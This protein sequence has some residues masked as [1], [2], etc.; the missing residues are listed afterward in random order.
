MQD[1]ENLESSLTHQPLDGLDMENL[2]SLLDSGKTIEATK[3]LRTY[4]VS[5]ER[6]CG[7]LFYA[8]ELFMQFRLEDIAELTYRAM[9]EIDPTNVSALGRLGDLYQKMGDYQEAIRFF[10]HILDSQQ[11]P[12][13]WVF[14]GL[15][16]AYE[17]QGKIQQAIGFFKKAVNISKDQ[18]ALLL[19]IRQLRQ[20]LGDDPSGSYYDPV[21]SINVGLREE[22]DAVGHLEVAA[23]SSVIREAV[24][25]GWVLSTANVQLWLEKD[26]GE[27][28]GLDNALWLPR[29]DVSAQ[30]AD[31]FVQIA[32]EPGFIVRFSGLCPGERIKLMSATG[33]KLTMLAEVNCKSFGVTAIAA[34]RWLFSV[35]TPMSLMEQRILTIDMP[36]IENL[37]HYEKQALN[38]YPVQERQL[39]KPKAAPV[40]S[41]I[42]PL[43][44]RSDFVEHQLIEF[45]RDTWF[46]ENAEL[47]YVVDDPNLS[48]SFIALAENLFRLYRMPFKWLWGNSNRGF[49]GANNLGVKHA[50]GQY[51]LFLNSDVFPQQPGWLQALLGVLAADLS[52][53]AVGPRLVFADGSIQHA[54]MAFVRREELGIW[55]NHHPYRGLDPILDPALEL[56]M[57]PAV[58]G[59]CML[60]RRTHLEKV[61]GWDSEYLIGDFED[62]DLCLKLHDVG[63]KVAYYPK[64]Q[65]THL[66]RQSFKLFDHGDFRFRVVLYNAVRHQNRWQQL[67]KEL[68]NEPD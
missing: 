60:I 25:V 47:I 46:V 19:R 29:Q 16:N 13:S 65:L 49:S 32:R 68:T 67:L 31:N 64:V 45:S 36:I 57:L 52:I 17:A 44:G 59:A 54:G 4:L 58:T 10:Q 53:G 23:A 42:V 20:Q 33:D 66:E 2:T 5:S 39:G 3:L 37:L 1:Q 28:I 34:A 9:L 7:K 11:S 63:L 41:V 43:Y 40:V 26:N 18:P 55:I 15:G 8:A 56:S 24:V 51:L 61:G 48:E 22:M 38:D 50:K 35:A 62:S 30:Y 12:E 27:R 21:V 14:I 6:E